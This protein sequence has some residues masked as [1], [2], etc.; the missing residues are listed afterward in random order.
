M[1]TSFSYISDSSKP[2][3]SVSSIYKLD[4]L[5]GIGKSEE[6]LLNMSCRVAHVT[7]VAHIFWWR[8]NNGKQSASVREH[9]YDFRCDIT[10][11]QRCQIFEW[12]IKPNL[13]VKNDEGVGL[14]A[15]VWVYPLLSVGEGAGKFVGTD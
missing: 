5:A 2:S 15:L 7:K 12:R 14:V 11:F 9:W 6:N 10:Y 13:W 1:C 8:H 3:Q 4:W